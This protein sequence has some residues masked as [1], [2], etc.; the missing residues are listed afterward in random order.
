[1]FHISASID[2]GLWPHAHRV[3]MTMIV[4]SSACHCTVRLLLRLSTHSKVIGIGLSS[5][6]VDVGDAG[7][8][9]P[10]GS[11][12]T[13]GSG[14]LAVVS[15]SIYAGLWSMPSSGSTDGFS[16]PASIDAVADAVPWSPMWCGFEDA[17]MFKG[18]PSPMSASCIEPQPMSSYT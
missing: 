13:D 9:S 14:I 12:G 15:A 4:P 10:S 18:Q 7:L 5:M 1:M 17:M 6:L 8:W 3:S 2:A 11:G 16:I